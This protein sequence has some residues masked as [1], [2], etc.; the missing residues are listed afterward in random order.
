MQI[1]DT[2]RFKKKGRLMYSASRE[3]DDDTT[4]SNENC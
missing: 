2:K 4:P 1:K 3:L